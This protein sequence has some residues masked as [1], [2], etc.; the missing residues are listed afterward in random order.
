MDSSTL[1]PEQLKQRV[2]I[3]AKRGRVRD[4]DGKIIFSKEQLLARQ[5]HFQEKLETCKMRTTNIKR[6]LK[7]IEGKL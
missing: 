6:I 2:V 3:E 7:E 5:S 1:T 4:E